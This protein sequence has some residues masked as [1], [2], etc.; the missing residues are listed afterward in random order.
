MLRRRLLIIFGSL[1]VLL[2]AMAVAAV[3]MLQGVLQ[4]LDHANELAISVVDQTSRLNSAITSVE[5]DLYNFQTGKE[6]HLDRLIE[7]VEKV[8][9]LTG[10]IG[11]HYAIHEGG[12]E[13]YYQALCRGLPRFERSV[14][15]LATAQD[16]AL[17]RQYSV[18]SIA[19]AIELRRSILQ[20]DQNIRGYARAE[21]S[22][23]AT[24]FRWVVLGMALGGLLVIN[25]SV[26]F[27]LRTASMVLRPVDTLVEAGRQ[28]AHEHFDFRAH[29]ER[30]DEFQELA[31]VYNSLAERLQT[32]EQRKIEMMGQVALTLNHELNNAIATI[33]LQLQVLE[34]QSGG[35]ARFEKCLRQIRDSLHRMAATVESLKH[36]RRIVLTDYVAGVKMLDLQRSVQ[37]GPA[38][39]ESLSGLSTKTAVP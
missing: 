11:A 22:A 36:I 18:E 31:Q 23:L 25:L 20:I 14:S 15:S 35:N 27:L 29:L 17:A 13:V 6:R 4:D 37:D 21:Q 28:L 38:P 24:R 9:T 39:K 34:R 30:R 32:H 10:A 1:V 3:W 12:T 2:A 19:T 5:I 33:S 8:G 16:P 26:I 7:D